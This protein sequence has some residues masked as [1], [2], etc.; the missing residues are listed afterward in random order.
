MIKSSW[1]ATASM[2]F[3]WENAG[4]MQTFFL[5]REL[6]KTYTADNTTHSLP[7]GALFLGL[8]RALHKNIQGQ[9]GFEFAHTGDAN[10]SGNVWDDADSRFNNY[11]YKYVVQHTQIALKGKLIGDLG[12]PIQPWVSAAIGVGF[13]RAVNFSNSPLIF[14]AVSAPNFTSHTT[15][16]FAYTLGAGIEHALT[17]QWKVGLGYEFSDWGKSQ[18][19][20]APGQT[21]NSGLALSHLYTSSV[22]LN[23]TYQS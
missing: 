8:Q 9:L 22:L 14:E 12:W 1:V 23:L 3:L 5:A 18:L 13:N 7:S 6:E 17:K 15:T 2:G 4:K 11:T 16:A 21:L 20:S 10:L 19:A